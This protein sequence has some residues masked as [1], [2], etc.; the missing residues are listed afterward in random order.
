MHKRQ[1]LWLDLTV[2]LA[3]YVVL[4]MALGVVVLAVIG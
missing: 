1:P 2:L 3:L 4:A